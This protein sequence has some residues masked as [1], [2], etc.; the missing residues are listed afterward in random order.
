M[1]QVRDGLGPR[2]G[3][4]LVLFCIHRV[5]RVYGAPA[6]VHRRRGEGR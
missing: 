3:G 6:H 2:V 1:A 4:L 5:N